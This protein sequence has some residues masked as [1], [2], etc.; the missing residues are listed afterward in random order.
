MQA[1]CCTNTAELLWQFAAGGRQH[2]QMGSLL[3]GS[4]NP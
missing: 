3:W 2:V 1:R 4:F